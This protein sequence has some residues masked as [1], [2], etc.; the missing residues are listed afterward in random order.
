MFYEKKDCEKH[1]I[2]NIIMN[3]NLQQ[4]NLQNKMQCYK[5]AALD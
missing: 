2:I 4:I 3:I 1:I 5:S